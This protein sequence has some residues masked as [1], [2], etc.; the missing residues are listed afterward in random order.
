MIDPKNQKLLAILKEYSTYP[1]YSGL[2]VIDINTVS[3]FGDYP[4]NIAAIIGRLDDIETLL[5]FGADINSKGE[6]G[7]TPLHYAVEQGNINVVKF[8]LDH[9]V[10]KDISNDDGDTALALSVLL[11][12]EKIMTLLSNS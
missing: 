1:Q 8:L 7:Y 4:I 10:N 11:G 6:Y 5:S 12:E 2:E 3:L 9:G